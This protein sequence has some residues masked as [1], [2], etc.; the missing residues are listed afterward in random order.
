MGTGFEGHAS[1]GW[2]KTTV[3][4]TG[5]TEIT[6]RFAIRDSGERHLYSTALIDS[7]AF[8]TDAAA[9]MSTVGQ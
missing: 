8:S 1:T 5:G 4:V 2:L 3:P 7:F 9:A 6:L